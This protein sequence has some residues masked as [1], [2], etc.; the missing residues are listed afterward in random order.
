MTPSPSPFPMNGEGEQKA[1]WNLLSYLPKIACPVLV[2]QGE[3][4][5]YGSVKQ[6]KRI[7]TPSPNPFPVNGEGGAEAES[8]LPSSIHGGRV[9]DGGLKK[10]RWKSI[11]KVHWQY[12]REMRKEATE[13]EK[14]LWKSLAKNQL[15]VSFRRQ[16]PIGPFIV[17][18]FASSYGLVIEV[19][20]GVHLHEDAQEYDAL[21]DEQMRYSGLTV[22]RF[23]NDDVLNRL[24]WVLSEI[25]K[26]T[27][28]PNPFPV[29][30]EGGAQSPSPNP[31]PVNGEGGADARVKVVMFA[32]VGHAPQRE[33]MGDV[34]RKI[35]EW[36][37]DPIP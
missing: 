16:H 7:Q 31:F 10:N 15:G 25:R 5:E 23:S 17:D 20:G 11:P 24:D 30:G 27:P 36:L 21:R 35:C 14:V 19:D 29:N 3:L 12:A 28:S 1:G 34:V 2:M 8:A 33:C 4:D 9:G 13:A 32:G 22:I 26:Q 6:V 37:T 18:F